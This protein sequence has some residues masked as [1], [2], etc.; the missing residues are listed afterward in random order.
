MTVSTPPRPPSPARV[1]PDSD[2]LSRD[3]IEAL[4][5]ALIEE[6]RQETRRRHRRYWAAAALV[7]FVGV[8][9]LALLEGGAASQ[10]ASP[11]VSARIG[12]GGHVGTS[13]I[14]FL[15]GSHP[16]FNGSTGPNQLELDVI[17]AD[18]SGLR[19]LAHDSG[20]APVWSPDGRKLV[21]GKRPVRSGAPCRPARRC[22]D[23]IYVINADG[24]GLRRLTRNTV[25]DSKPGWSPDGRRIAFVRDRDRQTANIYVMNADGSGQRRLTQNLRRRPWVELAWSP[26]WR[27]IAFVASASYVGA[28]DIFVINADGSGLRNVTN[29]VTTSFDFAWS[30]DGR[31]IAYLEASP[32]KGGGPLSVVNADGTGKHPLKGTLMVDLG[33]PSWSPDGRTIAFTGG[34]VIYT[35]H[36]N[37]TGLRELT[38]GPGHNLDPNGRRMGGGS[39][40][41]VSATISPTTASTSSS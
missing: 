12:A 18:G 15:R 32:G 30:P 25:V 20:A 37:G 19:R 22:S 23:E 6:A 5:E 24:T 35:V 31:R 40:S 11:A 27:K 2:R 7:S 36:A 10:T 16:P 8:G 29:T 9:L 1:T 33:L 26:D 28:P 41:S 14:A 13:R 3:E 17:N 21:F 39:S 4:V 34:S 38:H